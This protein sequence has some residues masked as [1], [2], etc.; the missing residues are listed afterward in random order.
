MRLRWKLTLA[1][2]VVAAL[3]ALAY[4][5]L[6]ADIRAPRSSLA[7]KQEIQPGLGVTTADFQRAE[8][9]MKRKWGPRAQTKIEASGVLTTT[10]DGKV[11][12][13]SKLPAEFYDASGIFVIGR[14]GQLE[15]TF[16]FHIDPHKDPDEAESHEPLTALKKRLGIEF[17]DDDAAADTCVA[18]S[19]SDLGRLGT[20]LRFETG[21]FC[22]VYWRGASPASMLI[23]VVLAHGDP[24]MRPFSERIC[25][26]L[27]SIA[28]WRVA[29]VDR[30]PPP[31]YAGCL[32]VDRP[33]HTDVGQML[34]AHVYEV[35]RDSTL[36][37]IN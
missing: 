26:S 16:P 4:A 6:V 5:E 1:A 36:A 21:T 17:N 19:S 28:L 13:Q 32:L 33:D 2:G 20:L 8:D 30:T 12:Q 37:R 24:W 22:V 9:E 15:S 10:V 11:V 34:R 18:L 25:R 7:K 29:D 3:A 14:P 35:R 31:D 23:G 27:T